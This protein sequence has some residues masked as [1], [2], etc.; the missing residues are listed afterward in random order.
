MVKRTT[1]HTQAT[2]PPLPPSRLVQAGSGR[3]EWSPPVYATGPL[4]NGGGKQ[5]PRPPT[6]AALAAAA[7]SHQPGPPAFGS[8]TAAAPAAAAAGADGRRG[9]S[10]MRSAGGVE[11]R[12]GVRCTRAK[13]AFMHSEGSCFF[14]CVWGGVVGGVSAYIVRWCGLMRKAPSSCPM[15]LFFCLY[16]CHP[17]IF[18]CT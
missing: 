10:A 14:L 17:F 1:V 5:P 8:V 6:E 13:C 18:S 9:G 11:C 7:F 12:Y 16:S 3:D 15:V 4:S 2:P